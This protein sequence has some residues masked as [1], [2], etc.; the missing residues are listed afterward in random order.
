[1]SN[2][3]ELMALR[4]G[5]IAAKEQLAAQAAEIAALRADNQKLVEENLRWRVE[6]ERL[7]PRYQEIAYE[8]LYDRKFPI[9]GCDCLTCRTFAPFV[10]VAKAAWAVDWIWEEAKH[11]SW[12]LYVPT[13]M[14][15]ALVDL[16]SALAHPTVQEG[17]KETQ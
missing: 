9:P 10:V 11:E 4:L 2:D 5:M 14:S 7:S 8:H 3:A 13:N 15:W 12:T 17:M 16:L 1:M 6:V